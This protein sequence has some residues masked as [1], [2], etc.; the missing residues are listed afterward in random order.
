VF[1]RHYLVS[2]AVVVACVLVLVGSFSTI[3]VSVVVDVS[4]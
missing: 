2:V 3:A 4:R 1:L